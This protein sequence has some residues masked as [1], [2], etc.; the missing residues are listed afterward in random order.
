MT[1]LINIG[2]ILV[3]VALAVSGQVAIKIGMKQIGY[4]TSGN[5][6]S[7]ILKSFSNWYVLFGL[8]AYALAAVTWI[9]VLSR[10]ELSYAYP[11]LSLGYVAIVL[12]SI[13]FLKE[14]LS[15]FRLL[16]T[17]L[18]IAGVVLIFKS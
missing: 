2:I 17:A 6:L 10:V 1:K 5:T 15:I 11:L 3:N 12:I 9:V 13:L 7:L 4:I 8:G 16:G 18:I 14:P